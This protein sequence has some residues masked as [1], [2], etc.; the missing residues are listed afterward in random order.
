MTIKIDLPPILNLSSVRN[1]LLDENFPITDYV[2]ALID[3]R[4]GG[5]DRNAWI[6]RTSA[7]DLAKRAVE[8]A[9][10]R[11]G[12]WRKKYPLFGIPFAVKD[13]ID[14][15]GIPT[16]AGCPGFSYLPDK[17]AP[18][19]TA[20]LDAGAILLGKTN[21]DQF[22][23]GLV[24]T[25]S[26][27]GVPINPHNPDF[28]PGGSSSGSAVAVATGMV[29]FALGT[30]TAGSGR[31][32]AA[33][34]G[35]VGLKPTRG[36]IS[37]RGVVPA[38]RSL[39]CISIFGSSVGDTEYVG[40]LVA[41]FDA[42]DPFSRRTACTVDFE[43][44]PLSAGYHFG[45][46][47]RS[48]LPGYIDDCTEELYRAG[49]ARLEELGGLPVP[50]DFTPFREV[51]RLLYSGPWLAERT[52]AVGSFIR[53]H[54]ETVLDVVREIILGGEKYTACDAF[55]AQHRLQTLIRD[56][57][58]IFSGIAY[59]ALPTAPRSYRIQEAIDRPFGVNSE[60]GY[61]TNFVN[62]LDLCAISVP[63][64]E[65]SSGVPFG[66]SLVAPAW[67]DAF[68]IRV[69]K[70]F[71]RESS[72]EGGVGTMPN[73]I[74]GKSRAAV[75]DRVDIAVVGAHGSGQPLNHEILEIGGFLR[76]RT[77]TDK[78]YRLYLLPGPSPSRP[79]L[80]RVEDG[81]GY[82]IQL[83]IWSIPAISLYHLLRR[84][85]SPLGIGSITLEDQTTVK[86]FICEGYVAKAAKDISEYGSWINYRAAVE[87]TSVNE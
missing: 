6:F 20:L 78:S 69:A 26:P 47:R 3:R 86:G 76:S 73:M 75:G 22:A 28:L 74:I 58:K 5:D 59:I 30:D 54:P 33:F 56:V 70:T 85:A 43:S 14:I 64:G 12:S 83:E 41:A 84:S 2:G 21:L 31:I 17:T 36:L 13:N 44:S 42:D 68:I 79:G 24:G 15:A 16:T 25:R 32:P 80:I 11:S 49:I 19:I 1:A 29:S 39:D 60:L 23:T 67:H 53:S 77:R 35:I 40:N 82:R 71:L 66:L 38:C 37:T 27:Y 87:T 81:S 8:L 62:L 61:F 7:R 63:A 51:A 52:V 65:F 34:N 50:I 10:L 46:L 55:L 45:V 57:G 48:D 72:S 4:D 18:V 9:A